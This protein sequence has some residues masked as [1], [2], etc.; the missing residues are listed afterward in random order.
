MKEVLVDVI[1]PIYKTD[2]SDLEVISLRQVYKVLSQHSLVVIKPASLDLSET[3]KHFPRLEMRSFDDHYFR[4]IPG[5]NELMLSE[6]FYAEFRHSKYILI[7]QLDAYVFKDDLTFW[8]EKGY[9]YIGAPWL[10]KSIYNFPIISG[11]MKLSRWYRRYRGLKSKQDLYN[12]I[13]NGGFS[14][15]KVDRFHNAT[16][17]YQEQIRVFLK[18]KSH[19]YNEDVFW[20]TIPNF[21]YPSVAEALE[22]SFDKYP[23]LCHKMNNKKL[24][25]GCHGW[26]KRK[27]RLFWRPIIGF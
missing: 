1:I 23:F 14:L 19:L 16:I 8:C 13:G 18:Q 27:A 24:P 22:F 17:K 2:L 4:G 10:K 26:Y 15:R 25:F 5:Y 9:D 7:Y 6:L 20:A 21:N 3:L 12:K 11:I